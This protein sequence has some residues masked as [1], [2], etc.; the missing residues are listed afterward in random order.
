MVA[1]LAAVP[2]E[3]PAAE[4]ASEAVECASAARLVL[5][6]D[7]GAAWNLRHSAC[8]TYLLH[9]RVL[10]HSRVLRRAF[11]DYPF[12]CAFVEVGL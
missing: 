4:A 10:V 5:M 2:V 8:P 1:R 6:V 12:L 9:S 11:Q 7:Q 3:A